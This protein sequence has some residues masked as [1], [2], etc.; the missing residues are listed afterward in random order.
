MLKDL[1]LAI[2]SAAVT[3]ASFSQAGVFG[4]GAV[5]A[6]AAALLSALGRAISRSLLQPR[7]DG[8]ELKLHE[9]FNP[10]LP[11]ASNMALSNK[12][13]TSQEHRHVQT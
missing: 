7:D 9:A 3:S 5:I 2:C 13:S 12:T 8:D 11:L 6:L 1:K 4:Y 10:L